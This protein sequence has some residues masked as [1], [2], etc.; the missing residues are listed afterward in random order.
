LAYFIPLK[1]PPQ[2]V[3]H[4]MSFHLSCPL[5]DE[6]LVRLRVCYQELPRWVDCRCRG[7]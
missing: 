3:L 7:F 2:Q 6:P 1:L 4:I 5:A